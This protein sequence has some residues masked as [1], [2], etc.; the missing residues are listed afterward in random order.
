MAAEKGESDRHQS[1][2]TLSSPDS[3]IHGANMGPTRG[4]QDPGG[5]HVGHVELAIRV[6]TTQLTDS[7]VLELN[8]KEWQFS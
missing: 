3:K 1:T 4:R 8:W 6:A 2:R 7:A 5:P